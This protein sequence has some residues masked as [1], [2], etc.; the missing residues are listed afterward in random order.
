MYD[1]CELNV[2]VN[3]ALFL[4]HSSF[5]TMEEEYDSQH[6]G[7]RVNEFKIHYVRNGCLFFHLGKTA[8]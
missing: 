8:M 5:S 2:K 7:F 6:N 4:T 3:H 1:G